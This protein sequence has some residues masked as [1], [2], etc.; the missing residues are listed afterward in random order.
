VIDHGL[1]TLLLAQAGIAALVPAQTINRNTIYPIFCNGPA[2]GVVPPFVVITA[3]GGDPMLTLESFSETLKEAEVTVR[4]YGFSQVDSETLHKTIRQFLDDYSGAAGASDTIQAVVGWS[5]PDTG[6]EV[7]A[8][9]L[10][11]KFYFTETTYT[12]QYSTP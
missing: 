11:S 12:I 8:E 6:Y 7:Q 3:Q 10:D 1:R 2:Q 5:E 4:S 9:G